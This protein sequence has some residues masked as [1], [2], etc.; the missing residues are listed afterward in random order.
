MPATAPTRKK[1]RSSRSILLRRNRAQATQRMRIDDVPPGH[2]FVLAY[3]TTS[4]GDSVVTAHT[5]ASICGVTLP[6]CTDHTLAPIAV[7]VGQVTNG[8]KVD[9]WNDS[10]R[11]WPPELKP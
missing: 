11:S 7:T 4:R 5:K 1:S 8:V 10:G 2:Y 6:S 3:F 9:D